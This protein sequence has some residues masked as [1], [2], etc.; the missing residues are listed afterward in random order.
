SAHIG[1]RKATP[2][3]ARVDAVR[4]STSAVH[5]SARA[6]PYV[7]APT[8]IPCRPSQVA[9]RRVARSVTD[10]CL[11]GTSLCIRCCISI[12]SQHLIQSQAPDA[13]RLSLGGPALVQLEDLSSGCADP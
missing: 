2:T 8:A 10:G 7:I 4:V 11:I 13:P 3:S 9:A 5:P 1:A 12:V 6:P